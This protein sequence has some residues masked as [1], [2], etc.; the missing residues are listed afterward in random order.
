MTQATRHLIWKEY[1]AQRGF[2]WGLLVLACLPMLISLYPSATSSDGSLRVNLLFGT[3][4]AFPAIYLLG[5]VALLFAGEFETQSIEYLRALPAAARRVFWVKLGTASGG[6]LLLIPVM[7]L[8]ALLFARGQIPAADDHLAFLVGAVAAAVELGAWSLLLSQLA[9]RVLWSIV[10][11]AGIAATL[12]LASQVVADQQITDPDSIWAPF[13]VSLVPR[14]LAALCALAIAV[15]WAPQWL[16]NAEA[17]PASPARAA[18]PTRVR[19]RPEAGGTWLGFR[20]LLWHEYRQSWPVWAVILAIYLALGGLLALD[21]L[22]H[23]GARHSAI[24]SRIAILLIPFSAICG[25]CVFLADQTNGRFRFFAEQGVAARSVWWSRIGA[26]SAFVT[27]LASV[28]ALGFVL[29]LMLDR[30]PRVTSGELQLVFTQMVLLFAVGQYCSLFIRSAVLAFF[31]GLVACLMAAAW[32]ALLYQVRLPL[33]VL[34]LPWAL[35]LLVASRCLARD[36]LL[37]VPRRRH[38]LRTSAM[39]VGPLGF[40]LALA[41]LMRAYEIPQVVVPAGIERYRQEVDTAG[42]ETARMYLRAIQVNDREQAVA[43]FLTAAGRSTFWVPPAHTMSQA[44]VVP[45]ALEAESLR[46]LAKTAYVAADFM[47]RHAFELTQQNQLD[48][49]WECQWA[50]IQFARHL[51]TAGDIRFVLAAIS[52]ERVVFD[53]LLRSA[54]APNQTPRNLRRMLSA[55]DKE[56]ADRDVWRATLAHAYWQMQDQLQGRSVDPVWNGQPQATWLKYMRWV[57]PWEYQRLQRVVD[58]QVYQSWTGD[59][60]VH[61]SEHELGLTPFANFLTSYVLLGYA[62][63]NSQHHRMHELQRDIVRTQL[64]LRLHQLEHGAYPAEL[65]EILGPHMADV[66]RWNETGTSLQYQPQGVEWTIWAQLYSGGEYLVPPGQP[67]LWFDR[68]PTNSAPTDEA[69]WNME[70]VY[71]VP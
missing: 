26:W 67:F 4:L 37:E 25:T 33:F 53:T 11:A 64:A 39:L 68:Y 61:L 17:Q 65:G 32:P 50:Q 43:Q 46:E 15:R 59:K 63:N 29:D 16:D 30:D 6:A 24:F 71:P 58:A 2:W 18:R 20:R 3:A 22:L 8:L 12:A 47:G 62:G 49:A 1:R 42:L 19:S 13:Y 10:G 70:L 48:A 21:S 14:L 35:G 69:G 23:Q 5:A 40:V 7:W 56:L 41:A 54:S 27:V 51:A 57:V 60:V 52:V 36:W 38:W 9:R 55:L 31:A 44:A 45:D 28:A 66:P 34:A